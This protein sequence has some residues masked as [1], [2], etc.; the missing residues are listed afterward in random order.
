MTAVAVVLGRKG[1]GGIGLC[2]ARRQRRSLHVD[3]A[4]LVLSP[5]S[6]CHP[7]VVSCSARRGDTHR[8][9]RIMLQRVEIRAGE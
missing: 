7:G 5:R 2:A 3:E 9:T 6:L 1:F 8:V 4:A